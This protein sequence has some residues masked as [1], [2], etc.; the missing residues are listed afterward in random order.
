MNALDQDLQE[1]TVS[2]VRMLSLVRESTDLARRALID[3]EIE[4]AELCV[5]N[6]ARVDRHEVEIEH[7]ILTI[8]ARRQPAAKD[9]RFLVAI[10]RALAAI[11]RAGD[12]AVRVANAG[13]ELAA[14]PPLKKYLDM[15]RIL[16]ILSGM[17]ETTIRAIAESD[18]AAARQVLVMDN[19]IDELYEQIQ[20]ELLTYMIEDPNKITAA[21]RLLTVTRSLERLGDHL[22]NVNEH[23]LFWLTGERI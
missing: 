19:E 18:Q 13:A 11:E 23:V 5:A 3:A 6:D 17:I 14:E 4:A 22:E 12:Y 21:T 2:T 9:L 16:D 10:F 20:R 1:I 7:R 8:M 15:A